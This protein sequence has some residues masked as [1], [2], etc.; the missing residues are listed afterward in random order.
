[1][2]LSDQLRKKIADAL[3]TNR[4]ATRDDLLLD[5]DAAI[6]LVP[7]YMGYCNPRVT[8]MLDT[9]ANQEVTHLKFTPMVDE[10]LLLG[11]PAVKGEQG[12][13]DF[14]RHDSRRTGEFNLR[15]PLA[16]FNM[17][18]SEDRKLKLPVE[19]ETIDIGEESQKVVLIRVKRA[20]AK[21][22]TA[23]ARRKGS[24]PAETFAKLGSE[25]DQS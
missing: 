1:M 23:Q 2:G 25:P 15:V 18:F 21:K 8:N 5:K 16:G 22:R 3:L 24:K 9:L 12:A 6:T 13:I 17:E 11:R 19:V 20:E 4:V 14:T 7:N 10:G